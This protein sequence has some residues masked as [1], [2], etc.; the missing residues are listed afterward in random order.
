[1]LFSAEAPPFDLFDKIVT[2]VNTQSCSVC[3]FCEWDAVRWE[4]S[5]CMGWR[6]AW[7]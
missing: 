2:Q 5:L 4:L 7:C 6:C 1:M 3:C